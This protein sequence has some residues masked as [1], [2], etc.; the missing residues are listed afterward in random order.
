[1]VFGSYLTASLNYHSLIIYLNVSNIVDSV[2]KDGPVDHGAAVPL[3]HVLQSDFE[4]WLKRDWVTKQTDPAAWEYSTFSVLLS[5][6]G[7]EFPT[8]SEYS[9][10]SVSFAFEVEGKMKSCQAVVRNLLNHIKCLE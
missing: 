7:G 4:T 8:L 3:W 1:M 2:P 6:L 9:S 5:E 10:V